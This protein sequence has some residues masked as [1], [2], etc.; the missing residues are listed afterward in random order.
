MCRGL[1]LEPFEL[2]F[3]GFESLVVCFL[4]GVGGLGAYGV[5]DA[6][7]NDS[8]NDFLVVGGLGLGDLEDC[9][10]GGDCGEVASEAFGLFIDV[11]GETLSD[12]EVDGLNSYVH[13]ESVLKG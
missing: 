6:G 2:A 13:N 7:G 1:F 8:D 3:D 9:V 11:V 10:D 5:V 4:E 12:L